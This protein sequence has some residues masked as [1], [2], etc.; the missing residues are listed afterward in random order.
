MRTSETPDARRRHIGEAVWRIIRR[1]GISAVSTRAVAA[2]ADMA[3]G[4]LRHYFPRQSDVLAFAMQL[5]VDRTARRIEQLTAAARDGAPDAQLVLEQYLPLDD[6]RREEMEVWL[7]F[8]GAT[9]ADE[10]LEPAK[11]EWDDGML[12]VVRQVVASVSRP[13]TSSAALDLAADRLRALI[14]GLAAHLVGTH[15][16]L[17]GGR[18]RAIL[19]DELSRLGA[20]R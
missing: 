10:R 8:V 18:A 20:S 5:V 6:E 12:A 13:G 7:A 9:F 3:L 11:R 15:P 17:E 4:S 19:A 2:E 16:A 14:D 1:D